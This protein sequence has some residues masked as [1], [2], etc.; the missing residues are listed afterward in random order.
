M[1]NYTEFMLNFLDKIKNNPKIQ[2]TLCV[3][4]KDGRVRRTTDPD[5]M[6]DILQE[7]VDDYKEKDSKA[8]E[9]GD[10]DCYGCQYADVCEGSCDDDD[11]DGDDWD[12]EDYL[13]GP[14]YSVLDIPVGGVMAAGVAAGAV[15]CGLA[16]II[17]A[18]KK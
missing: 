7:M 11:D 10:S 15:L 18:L 5:E 2:P 4:E 8:C 1:F 6:R 17:H 16:A 9:D 13:Y 12:I 3:V 14:E